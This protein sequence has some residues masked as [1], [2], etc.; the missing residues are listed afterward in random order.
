MY[1]MS[2]LGYKNFFDVKLKNGDVLKLKTPPFRVFRRILDMKDILDDVDDGDT[3]AAAD[4]I[5]GICDMI[6]TVLN[7]NVQGIKYTIEDIDENFETID[8]VMGFLSEYVKW[9]NSVANSK[10][11]NARTIHTGRQRRRTGRA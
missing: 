10:N 7:T 8:D 1:D 3:R 6:L 5:D 2:M 9:L 4:A 11:F